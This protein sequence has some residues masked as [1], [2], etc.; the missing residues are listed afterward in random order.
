MRFELPTTAVLRDL[1]TWCGLFTAS[2]QTADGFMAG[3]IVGVWCTAY[4]FGGQ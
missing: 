2:N 3:I 4:R 1:A